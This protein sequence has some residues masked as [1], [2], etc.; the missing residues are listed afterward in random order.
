MNRRLV[1]GSVAMVASLPIAVAPAWSQQFPVAATSAAAPSPNFPVVAP[2]A[3]PTSYEANEPRGAVA[4]SESIYRVR[5]IVDGT[6]TV[7][8]TLGIAIPYAFSAHLITP[9]CPCS[10]RSVN[11]FDRGV[12]GNANDTADWISGVTVGLAWAL[13]PLLDWMTLSS[14][15]TLAEDLTVFVEALAVNG[16]LVTAAKYAVQRPIPRV[17]SQPGA[18]ADIGNYRS[19]YS[20]HTSNVFAALSVVSVTVD[21][22]YG[23]TWQPWAV[24]VVIGA[25]VAL[26]RVAAGKHFYSDVIVGAAAGTAV[27][28][29]VSSLHLRG[30]GPHLVVWPPGEKSGFGLG[31]TDSF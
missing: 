31:V 2:A 11:A 3:D 30:R 16:A 8:A 22:R 9:T 25:S 1:L 20:G 17:Y 7:I 24:T 6:V 29:L 10:P 27:G 21:R 5:P 23:W 28:L 26:E 19:F 12:I 18:A 13:P 4:T 15:K 14:K